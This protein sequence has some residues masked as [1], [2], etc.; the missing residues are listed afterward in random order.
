MGWS[1]GGLREKV[2]GK[3]REGVM[4]GDRGR[5]DGEGGEGERRVG[6]RRK[7]GRGRLGGVKEG[8]GWGEE[9][10]EEGGRGI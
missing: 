6:S 5:D 4:E 10:E 2:G 7:E 9:N 3:G 1:G 8:G